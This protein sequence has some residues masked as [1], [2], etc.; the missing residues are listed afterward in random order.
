MATKLNK[1]FADEVKEGVQALIWEVERLESLAIVEQE[2]YKEMRS[3]IDAL[4]AQ[5]QLKTAE[6]EQ[7]INER[8]INAEAV[9]R[10]QAKLK[11]AM[12]ALKSIRDFPYGGSDACAITAIK[13]LAEIEEPGDSISKS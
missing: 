5:L 11:R 4:K 1:K 12:E 8:A 13:A 7:A 6:A 2:T 3:E 10:L 9:V